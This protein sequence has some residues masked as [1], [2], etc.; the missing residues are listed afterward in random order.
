MLQRGKKLFLKNGE[1]NREGLVEFYKDLKRCSDLSDSD[2][3]VLAA[4]R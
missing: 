4:T 2:A 3:A 1:I